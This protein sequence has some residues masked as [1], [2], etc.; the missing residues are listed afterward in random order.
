MNSGKI[1]EH[2]KA[3]RVLSR[4][5]RSADNYLTLTG[6]LLKQLTVDQSRAELNLNVFSGQ[7]M[8]YLFKF[9]QDLQILEAEVFK[10]TEDKSAYVSL[11][12]RSVIDLL[13]SKSIRNLLYL[14]TL[15][16]MLADVKIENSIL[17][18]GSFNPLHQGHMELLSKAQSVIPDAPISSFE[19]SV[20]NCSKATI[21]DQELY[22]RVIQFK[23]SD[24]NVMITN[25]P[26]F[27][28]KTEFICGKSW[29]VIGADTFKRFFD[30]KFYES[31]SQVQE[32]SDFLLKSGIG[33]LV[34]PRLGPQKVEKVEDFLEMVP[35]SYKMYVKELS[36]FRVDLSS[37]ELRAK[38]SVQI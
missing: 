20:S 9:R 12:N 18:A 7:D 5:V 19:L 27:R 6:S 25:S 13:N 29:F 14:P 10:K 3:L 16:L 28:E 2:S 32:F 34:G 15:E 23:N 31:P 37:T 4:M 11:G 30:L 26:Y 24:F 35:E 21:G 22:R 17:L 36:S 38:K 33:L 1:L 8:I